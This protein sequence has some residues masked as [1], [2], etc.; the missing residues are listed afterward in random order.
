MNQNLTIAIAGA[1]GFIGRALQHFLIENTTHKLVCLSR[2][3][4][5]NSDTDRVEW[6]QCDLFSMKDIEAGL[7]D[8]DFGIYLVHSM[9]PSARLTQGDFQDFDLVISDN[10]A[11]AAQRN[12]LKRILYLGGIIP[13]RQVLSP[14]LASRLEVEE[15]LR[16]S[17][18][19]MTSLR[20]GL[21]IGPNGS[22]FRILRNLVE[23]LP[24]LV[25]PAWTRTKTC[26]VYIGDVVRA[27][28][29]AIRHEETADKIIDLAGDDILT[30]KRMM[31]LLAL[32][33]DKRR[34]FIPAPFFSPSLSRLWVRL[35][36]GAPKDL[37]YPLV[38]SLKSE[39]LPHRDRTLPLDTQ[40]YENMLE[41]ALKKEK[42][43][44]APRAFA[45]TGRSNDKNV[46][47]IQ[48]IPTPNG[49]KAKEIVDYYF[50]W[51]PR[52]FFP[53]LK[54]EVT[55]TEI[56]FRFWGIK[57]P[58]LLLHYSKER[59]NNRRQLFYVGDSILGSDVGRGRLE[60]RDTI[61]DKSTIA[62]IHEFKPKLP[63]YI[64]KYTQAII[65]LWVM[66]AFAKA[67]HRKFNRVQ[68]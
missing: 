59:S 35:I 5:S 12:N 2:R 3:D 46:R 9:L 42:M 29:Y 66:K 67:V 20:A 17:E 28:E 27:F 48:R 21:V 44:K 13:D 31:E 61:D 43:N 38:E 41:L 1:S 7:K 65:H 51:I 15:T 8:C 6:R 25:C 4:K 45:Y 49:T 10:F 57:R 50:H 33:L 60:F 63:W 14:H 19:P 64:Y 34:I 18:I 16:A 11:R 37:V 62:A 55:D 53:W 26:P 22:S 47:S 40:S 58:L 68:R 32:K 56:F 24:V 36:T 52:F 54:V 30:Y 39:M 23:R